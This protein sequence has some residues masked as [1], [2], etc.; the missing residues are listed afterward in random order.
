MGWSEKY[1]KSIDCDNPKGFSQRAHCQGKQKKMQEGNLHHWFKGSKSKDGKPGWVQSDGSPCANEPGETK[2]PKC[3]SSARLAALKRKGKKGENLI[4]S[5]DRRKRQQDP[6]QQSKSGAAKPTNV[7][8]FAKGKKNKHYVKPEPGLKETMEMQEGKDIKGKGSG[9][10]D[11]CYHEVKAS[12]KVWP[13]AYASGRLVQ[14]RKVGASNWGNKSEEWV[15]QTAAEYLFNE[16]LNE[17]GVAIFIEELGLDQFIDFIYDI[18][19]EVLA[20][21]KFDRLPP[22]S[23]SGKMIK[24]LPKG[25]ARSS[26]IKS[27]RKT[28][29]VLRQKVDSESKSKPGFASFSKKASEVSSQSKKDNAS[30]AVASAKKQQPKK[31][32]ILD[33]VAGEVLKGM[34]RH[35][36]AMAAARETGKTISKAAKV[37]AKGAQEFGKGFKSGVETAGK[38]AKV[39]KKVVSDSYDYSNWREDFKAMEYEFIDIIKPEPLVTEASFEI[40]HTSADVRRAEKKKKIDTLAQQGSTEGERR[41]AARKA[42]TSLPPIRKEEVDTRRAPAELVAR[43]SA[44]REGEMAQDGPNKPAYDAKQRILAKTKA[45]RMKEEV[46]SIDELKCWKGYKRKKGAV[47]GEK[48]S[49]VKE[50]EEVIEAKDET[51]I[52][53]TGLPIPK[54]KRSPEKQYEFEKKRRENLGRNVGGKTY[55]ADVA[56]YKTNPRI[57]YLRNEEMENELGEARHTPTKS[58]L[59]A[60]IG[61]GNLQKLSKKASKRIDYDVD[62]DVDPNDKVEKKTGEYGE[63]LP[64]P[65]GK[66]RTGSSKTVKTKKEEFSDWRNQL[67]EKLNL[68]KTDMGDVVKDFYDSD[69]PQFK[70]KS[71]EK[72]REMAIAAKL[73]AMREDWQVVN[74]KDKTDGMSQKAVDTYRRENPG[75]KLKTAVT[76]DPKP[77]SKDAKRRKSFCARS[78]GQQDM[79]NI[80]CSKTPDKPVC[81]AR[82]RWKC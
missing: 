61:G 22:V 26:A 81:K 55:S 43:L 40:K 29:E 14:C 78:K 66:F 58:D 16:G 10:K 34:E 2:T 13:S 56:P 44:R 5:A 1:K 48:G 46:E 57:G 63:E 28:R 68:K 77:G 37:G 7:K 8:T 30:K 79:H 74:K 18:G 12:A 45:K 67:D 71:K 70:G 50:N 15:A 75:S 73:S 31:K 64:T 21:A 3:Y 54:K 35:K 42:G 59:E 25:G 6:G 76:G 41:A 52:G 27:K 60:N 20:E 9:K 32:G 82:R 69:A 39:A 51:E 4:K 33:R 19:E 23:K 24:D 62:G 65:F 17:D 36:A 47:P 80:D 49:C 53:I 38:V 11:A 72:R